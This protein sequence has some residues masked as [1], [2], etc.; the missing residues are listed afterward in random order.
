MT[1]VDSTTGDWYD[2]SAHLLWAGDRTRRIDGAHVEFLR[3]IKN[4]VA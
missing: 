4:P 2:T 1:R 3:G